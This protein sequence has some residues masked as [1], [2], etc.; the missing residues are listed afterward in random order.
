MKIKLFLLGTIFTYITSNAQV[1]GKTAFDFMRLN[2]GARLTALGGENISLADSDP[3]L[4][5]TN[6]ASID[7]SQHKKLLHAQPNL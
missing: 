6:P 2:A 3:Y 7:T 5:L 4:F 1:G